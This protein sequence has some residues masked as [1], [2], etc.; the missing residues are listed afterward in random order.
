MMSVVL[1]AV[2]GAGC[3]A[4]FGWNIHAPGLLSEEFAQDISKIPARVALYIPEGQIDYLSKDKG[5]ALSDPQTYY[6][7]EAYVPMLI[8]SFQHGVDEFLLFETLP[9]TELMKRYAISYLVVCEIKDFKNRK[10]YRGQGLDLYTETFVFNPDLSLYARF[11]TRGASEA[12]KVFAKKGGPE[13]NL[14]HAIESNLRSMMTYLQ[15]LLIQ[16]QKG[17]A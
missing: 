17:T 16:A 2:F 8:E 12:W 7:G 11:E 5:T 6:I 1:L 10:H 15:D 14:N 4:L 13:V 9:T 3:A